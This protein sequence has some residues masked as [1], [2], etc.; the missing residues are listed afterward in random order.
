MPAAPRATIPTLAT[1]PLELTTARLRLRPPRADDAA[2]MFAYVSDPA[3]PVQM[4]WAAHTDIAETH[5]FI[6]RQRAATAANTD[7][8]WVIELDGKLAGG[9]GLHNI[10]WGY[11]A[12][13][14]DRAIIGYWLAT[15][16]RRQGYM[17]EALAAVLH[18]AFATLGLHKIV[19]SCFSENIGSRR[20]IEKTGFR[21]TGTLVDDI[22]RDGRWHD[23][24]RYEMTVDE[25]TA[26]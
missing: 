5:D 23:H 19:I 15:E 20:V 17:T 2:P 16:H 26:R 8:F 21:F 4:T 6:A 7:A 11:R 14:Q 12:L 10:T 24:L 1:L 9:I 18:F 13:R 22:W 25:W 3:L